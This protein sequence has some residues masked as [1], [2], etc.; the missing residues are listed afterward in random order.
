MVLARA[1]LVDSLGSV[2]DKV[3]RA[4]T[5]RVSHRQR[6]LIKSRLTGLTWCI[7]ITKQDLT[8]ACNCVQYETQKTLTHG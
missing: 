6:N 2:E 7:Q 5:N 4:T 3:S 1:I 8:K